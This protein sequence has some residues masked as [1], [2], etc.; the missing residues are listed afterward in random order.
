MLLLFFLT[1]S[2][3]ARA[4]PPRIEYFTVND[5]LSTRQINDLHVGTD[6]FL[7]V[8]TSDG[9]NRFDGSRFLTFGQGPF[10]ETQLSRGDIARIREDNEEQLIITFREFTGY[11]DRFDPRTFRAERIGL[12]PSNGVEG[13]ARTIVTD[14]QGRTFVVTV[15]PGGTVLY[16]YTAPGFTEIYRQPDEPR[17]RFTARLELL[18]LRNGQFLLYDDEHGFKHLSATG[19]LIGTPAPP[20]L[21]TTTR[22]FYTFAEGPTGA[23]FLSFRDGYPLYRWRPELGADFVPVPGLDDGLR[24]PTM[25]TDE[26]GQLLLP[27]TEDILGEGF[28]DEYYLVNLRGEFALFDLPMPT[29]RAVTAIAAQDFN[30]TLYLG[31]TEGLGVLE[32]YASPVQTYL[33][34]EQEIGRDPGGVT[35]IT[36]DGERTFILQQ[37]GRLLAFPPGG[38][39]PEELPLRYPDAS[40]VFLRDARQ[41]LYDA[42]GDA[43]WSVA[44]PVAETGG[45]LLRYSLLDSTAQTYRTDFP[46]SALGFGPDGELYA[47]ATDERNTGQL[48]RFDTQTEEFSEVP[49]FRRAGMDGAV[50]VRINYLTVDDPHNQLLI[51]THN[52]GVIGFNPVDNNFQFY[53]EGAVAGGAEAEGA[54]GVLNSQ[55]INV[56]QTDPSG[57]WW[58]GTDGGLHRYDPLTQMVDHYGRNRGLSSNVVVGIVP[59]SVGGY[60]LATTNG[61]THLP[62]EPTV[63]SLRRYYRED[64]LADSDLNPFAAYRNP[65]DGRYFFGGQNGLTVFRESDLNARAAGSDVM[66][67]EVII[68]GRDQ[69]RRINRQLDQVRQVTMKPSEKSI[70]I[71]LALPVGQRPTSSR[72][73]V[74]LA[75]FEGDEEWRE[76]VGEHTVRYNNLP[77]GTYELQVQ[78]GGANGNYGTTTRTLKIHV[79][80]AFLEQRWFQLMLA[81]FIV[82]LIVGILQGKL[83]ERLRNEQLRTQLSSDIHDEVSGLLAGITLQTELLKHRTDDEKLRE[84]LDA[85]GEAGRS[86]MSKM[87]DVIWSIDSRRDTIGNLLQRMQE[88]ADEVLLPLEIRYDFRADG[89]DRNRNLAGTI[90]QDIYFIYKEAINNIARHSNATQVTIELEQFAQSFEMYIHDNGTGVGEGG[91]GAASSAAIPSSRTGVRAQFQEASAK[92]GQGRDNLQMRATRLGGELTLDN[93]G[94][95][96][97]ILRMRKL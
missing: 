77:E 95:Y 32:R 18:P 31:L 97:L 93:R 88:H 68:Y 80:Q 13:Y 9:L 1:F 36:G 12:V 46:L 2:T 82:G 48:L 85:V 51:G 11:F 58:L 7:W 17:R 55:T 45:I 78:G 57:A 61:L 3:R 66:L 22:R 19:E 81:L 28:P 40:A 37:G 90:R 86:A 20:G 15:G 54:V 23:V 65:T 44:Q 56:I 79:R 21:R 8:A 52:R 83:R 26:R 49:G 74:R 87:S 47:G 63:G 27:A 6:G 60:W 41:L 42:N 50:G 34:R 91:E 76:L 71:G 5:G 24:Y 72:F 35:G 59:D 53:H 4:Q 10:S 14:E 43:L 96:T 64:G 16:E 62:A 92:T 73:R 29:E 25:S 30:E 33:T 67:T 70:A 75:G 84:K 39:L 89:F 69:E 94:G 38:S